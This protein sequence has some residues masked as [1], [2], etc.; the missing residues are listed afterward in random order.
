MQTLDA[1]VTSAKVDTSQ[2]G[3]RTRLPKPQ[4]LTFPAGQ[5]WRARMTTSK[6]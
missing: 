1:L 5:A 4:L 2:P 6:G 3:W